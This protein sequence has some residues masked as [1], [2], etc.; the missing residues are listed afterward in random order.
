MQANPHA[1]AN[2]AV[3]KSPRVGAQADVCNLR[4]KK[5]GKKSPRKQAKAK[6]NLAASKKK[7]VSKKN[8]QTP[9][10]AAGTTKV[11]L[12]LASSPANLRQDLLD[13]QGKKVTLY[14]ANA[15]MLVRTEH[16]LRTD[17]SMEDGHNSADGLYNTCSDVMRHLD[18]ESL[19]GF[20]KD[21]LVYCTAGQRVQLANDWREHALEG[22]RAK[23]SRATQMLHAA[24]SKLEQMREAEADPGTNLVALGTATDEFIAAR[25]EKMVATAGTGKASAAGTKVKTATKKNKRKQKARSPALKTKQ[26]RTAGKRKAAQAKKAAAGTGHKKKLPRL[27]LAEQEEAARAFLDVPAFEPML[28][29]D[30]VPRVHWIQ[31]RGK[32]GFKGVSL[33]LSKTKCWRVK[34]GQKTVARYLT[35]AE[36]C[37]GYYEWIMHHRKWEYD[38]PATQTTSAAE[39]ASG[40]DSDGNSAGAAGAESDDEP[41]VIYATGAA[42]ER[43]LL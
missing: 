38:W 12:K 33:D 10:A 39:G 24:Q 30:F 7:V 41:Q 11:V 19:R 31:G 32:S 5:Q 29:K 34:V 16:A 40:A 43:I 18:L 1:V 35:K 14:L 4:K 22:V 15:K 28:D 37:Q 13:G 23:R 25:S 8:P 27:T 17:W 2:A 6:T 9:K 20:A 26:T 42:D 36:A 3:D 21:A